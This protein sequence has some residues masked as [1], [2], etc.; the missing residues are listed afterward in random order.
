MGRRIYVNIY[1]YSVVW[2][3]NKRERSKPSILLSWSLVV[4]ENS[5]QKGLS[6]VKRIM[7]SSWVIATLRLVM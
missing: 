5:E 4:L 3:E 7:T 1:V 6:C 2:Y